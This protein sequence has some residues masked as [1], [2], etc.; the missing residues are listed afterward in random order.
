MSVPAD[1]PVT[2][3]SITLAVALLLLHVPP[4]L[5]GVN[6]IVAP[7]QTVAAPTILPEAIPEAILKVAIAVQKLFV[8]L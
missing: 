6:V 2:T 7:L 5:S 4:V 3:P 1:T 8:L